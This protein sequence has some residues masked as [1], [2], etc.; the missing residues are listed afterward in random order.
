MLAEIV[1]TTGALRALYD[2]K[3]VCLNG[4]NSGYRIFGDTIFEVRKFVMVKSKFPIKQDGVY[5]V[6]PWHTCKYVV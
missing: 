2:G 5:I 1:D 6:R 4:S 3:L